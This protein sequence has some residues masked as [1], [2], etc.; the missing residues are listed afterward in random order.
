[1]P[2]PAPPPLQQVSTQTKPQISLPNP[3][4]CAELLLDDTRL[5]RLAHELARGMYSPETILEQYEIT[6]DEFN[7]RVVHNQTFMAY[8]A[9]A[10]DIWHASTN[11]AER[12]KLKSGVIF[13]EWLREGNRLLHDPLS[14]M[15]AKVDLAK[16]LGRI[17]GLEPKERAVATGPDRSVSIQINLNHA[18]TG[19]KT[20][21]IE[22][23]LPAE[24]TYYTPDDTK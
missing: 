19:P 13:E 18:E 12:I 24:V 14:P 8:Y 16:F 11:A 10:R 2:L 6:M 21:E 9:E 7:S 23:V 22:K 15:A 20:I 1:M 4:P 17:V 3:D 5:S